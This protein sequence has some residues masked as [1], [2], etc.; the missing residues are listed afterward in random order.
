MPFCPDPLVEAKTRIWY[1]QIEEDRLR[2]LHEQ[3]QLRTQ[4]ANTRVHRM[5]G[6]ENEL[7]SLPPR[8][9]T[10]SAMATLYSAM[11]NI[12]NAYLRHHDAGIN[13]T[14]LYPDYSQPAQFYEHPFH[15]DYSLNDWNNR[16]YNMR[17]TEVYNNRHHQMHHRDDPR[18]RI[19]TQHAAMYARYL[20]EI[21]SP[22][23][24]ESF[25]E[26]DP[27]NESMASDDTESSPSHEARDL[28]EASPLEEAH[29][30]ATSDAAEDH[31]ARTLVPVKPHRPAAEFL[32]LQQ[33]TSTIVTVSTYEKRF[34]RIPRMQ[35]NKGK[36]IIDL[37]AIATG[38]DVTTLLEGCKQA[39]ATLKA[40]YP[41]F[42]KKYRFKLCSRVKSDPMRHAD[43]FC[44]IVHAAKWTIALVD[45]RAEIIREFG[46][47]MRQR[48]V[49]IGFSDSGFCN[50]AQERAYPQQRRAKE[51]ETATASQREMTGTSHGVA[52]THH[53]DRPSRR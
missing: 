22:S 38:L 47:H 30:S 9:Q 3:A 32:I 16:T 24:P 31:P 33:N 37:M 12:S 44:A 13:K 4:Q 25:S 51:P 46:S 28:D 45:Q 53:Q 5:L 21:A 42:Y 40:K 49:F 20:A 35:C 2:E 52:K 17:A 23:A 29:P 34:G 26:S 27:A 39:Y 19:G 18:A 48:I 43:I 6:M 10:A 50:L 8:F 41:S 36:T 15:H 7:I 1:Y 14:T 11:N